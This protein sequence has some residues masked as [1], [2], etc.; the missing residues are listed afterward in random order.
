MSIVKSRIIGAVMLT[1]AMVFGALQL[2][3]PMLR[4]S[5]SDD[6]VKTIIKAYDFIWIFFLIAPFEIGKSK[7]RFVVKLV[8]IAIALWI[9]SGLAIKA[10]FPDHW[11]F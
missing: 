4:A 6:T 11:F 7:V 3:I 9:I 8:L 5:S 10:I 1:L 2:Y